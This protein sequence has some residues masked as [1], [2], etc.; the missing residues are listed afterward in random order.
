M[1][2]ALQAAVTNNPSDL[3]SGYS[4]LA[5][6]RR[7]KLAKAAQTDLVKA[8]QWSRGDVVTAEIASSLEKVVKAH[9]AKR[10]A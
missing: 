8:A 5:R 7:A 3:Q 10:K 1:R 4:S 9:L 2:G 6:G